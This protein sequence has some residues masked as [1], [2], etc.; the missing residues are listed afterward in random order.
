MDDLLFTFN[1][2][3][4]FKTIKTLKSRFFLYYN[5]A[6]WALNIFKVN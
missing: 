1:A 3:I 2:K 4:N 6:I 5:K